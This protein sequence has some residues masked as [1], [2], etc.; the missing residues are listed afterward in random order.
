MNIH[1]TNLHLNLVESDLRRMFSSY[2][3]VQSVKLIRHK[4]N[5][6]PQGRAFINMPVEKQAKNAVLNLNGLHIN[7][8][9]ISVTEVRY[10][11]NLNFHSFNPDVENSNSQLLG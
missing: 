7:G 11:P 3:E 9:N 10:D 4:M 8:K 6:R 2:G 1:V 5:H